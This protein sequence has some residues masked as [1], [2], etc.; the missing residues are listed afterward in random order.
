MLSLCLGGLYARFLSL[1]LSGCAEAQKE[2]SDNV[3]KRLEKAMNEL[4]EK[5]AT[6]TNEVDDDD[7]APTGAAYKALHQHQRQQAKAAALAKEQAERQT[8]S[9]EN[10][11][12]ISIKEQ[13][14][15]MKFNSEYEKE[16]ADNHDDEN[17]NSDSEDDVLYKK[18][19]SKKS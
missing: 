12:I 7:R 2:V 8:Q 3:Q 4:K 1:S 19:C 14:R 11:Q 18:L 6:G 16:N 13:M 5:H 17:D 9:E 10:A 15:R